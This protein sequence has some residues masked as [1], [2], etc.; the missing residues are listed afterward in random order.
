MAQM[1]TSEETLQEM[2]AEIKANFDMRQIAE[3]ERIANIMRA[4]CKT[5]LGVVA[6]GLVGAEVQVLIDKEAQP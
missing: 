3:I 5:D 1:P 6:L 4:L 2:H